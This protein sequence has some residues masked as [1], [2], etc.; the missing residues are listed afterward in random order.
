LRRP[1]EGSTKPSP[2]PAPRG[3]GYIVAGAR[4][5]R[6]DGRCAGNLAASEVSLDAALQLARDP[7]GPGYGSLDPAPAGLR[8][9]QK[10]DLPAARSLLEKS[11]ELRRN[12]KRSDEAS[13]SLTFLAAVALLQSDAPTADRCH[14]REPGI[15]RAFETAE[16]PGHSTFSPVSQRVTATW[17]GRCSW[18]VPLGHA[19][20]EWEHPTGAVGGFVSPH[21]QLARNGVDPDVARTK[22]ERGGACLRRSTGVRP[23]WGERSPGNWRPPAQLTVVKSPSSRLVVSAGSPRRSRLPR[24]ARRRRERPGAMQRRRPREGG[25][26]QHASQSCAQIVLCIRPGATAASSAMRLVSIPVTKVVVTQR[27]Q[28]GAPL[29][30]AS[31]WHRRRV[32]SGYRGRPPRAD[33]P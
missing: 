14:H 23:G 5:V 24:A 15:G 32:Q 33:L 7:W 6:L 28:G 8:A 22:W 10:P 16:R 31:P 21:V 3:I 17:S 26:D 11:V 1:A 20:S 12:L 30:S 2:R 18:P 27:R 19:R 13:I 4:E 25:P 29:S 9:S